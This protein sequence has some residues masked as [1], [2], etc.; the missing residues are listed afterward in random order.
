MTNRVRVRWWIETGLATLAF[1]LAVLTLFWK[2]WIEAV[3][4]VDPDHHSGSLEWGIVG[5]LAVIAAVFSAVAH[6]EWRRLRRITPGQVDAP[7]V[8]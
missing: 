6:A 2:D 7:P 8:G 1:G 5:G 3:F 4:R